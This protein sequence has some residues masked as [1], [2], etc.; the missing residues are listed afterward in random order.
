MKISVKNGIMAG[1]S[2]DDFVWLHKKYGVNFIYRIFSQ[3]YHFMVF[4]WEIIDK[5][6][7]KRHE[8]C[9]IFCRKTAKPQRRQYK[10]SLR[11]AR[12]VMR[13]NKLF[14]V[15]N[16]QVSTGFCWL[17]E[18]ICA[19]IMA[20]DAKFLH[21]RKNKC[22]GLGTCRAGNRKDLHKSESSCLLY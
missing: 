3:I 14:F 7:R 15:K 18:Q 12:N 21:N 11:L 2:G 13:E 19:V 8:F 17:T 10:K 22:D 1:F 9:H 20:L 6:Y 16:E 4:C 5:N